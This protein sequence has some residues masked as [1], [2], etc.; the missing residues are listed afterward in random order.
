MKVKLK[1]TKKE[2]NPVLGKDKSGN[3]VSGYEY[4]YTNT[5]ETKRWW[6]AMKLLC[7]EEPKKEIEFE[8]KEVGDKK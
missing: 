5:G 8:I 2:P 7:K 1:L 3:I 6:I 4:L